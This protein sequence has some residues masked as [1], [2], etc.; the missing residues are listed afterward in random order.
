MAVRIV[1]L[2]EVVQVSYRTG[3]WIA[4][5]AGSGELPLERLLQK[6]TVVQTGERVNEDEMPQL[7]AG[8]GLDTRRFVTPAVKGSTGMKDTTDRAGQGVK[9]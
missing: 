4:I 6:A 3:K 1:Y 7:T 9:V 8:N 2:L 5:A